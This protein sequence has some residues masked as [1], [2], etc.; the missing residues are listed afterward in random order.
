MK[1]KRVVMAI[2]ITALILTIVLVSVRAYYVAI[3]LVVGTLIIGYR[4]IWSLLRRKKLPALDERVRGNIN[5][6]VRNG[7]VFFAVALAFLMLPFS[8]GLL[9]A[10]DTVHVLGGV[11]V[12]G[13]L[14]YCLS[15]LFYDRA[16]PGL[17]E[18]GLEM[19]KIFLLVVGM[20]L[21]MVRP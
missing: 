10:G 13:G 5:K 7:F 16:Q 21:L 20:P 9:E 1:A 3:A 2:A 15:Y 6:S 12:A 11:F 14:V 19:L 4:E 8:V 18:R 17:D